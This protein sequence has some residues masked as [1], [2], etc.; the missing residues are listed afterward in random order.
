MTESEPRLMRGHLEILAAARHG[1]V[2]GGGPQ[3]D[4][5]TSYQ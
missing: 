3:P 1:R 4:A 2:T 5:R